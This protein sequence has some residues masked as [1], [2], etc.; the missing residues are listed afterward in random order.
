MYRDTYPSFELINNSSLVSTT[1][2]KRKST[3][4]QGCVSL[5]DHVVSENLSFLTKYGQVK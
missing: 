2:S 5:T 1:S 4:T 3:G